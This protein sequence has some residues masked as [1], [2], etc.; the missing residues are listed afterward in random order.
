[1]QLSS[2]CYLM[3]Y[4]S[5]QLFVPPPPFKSY[6]S[7]L[8]KRLQLFL[9]EIKMFIIILSLPLSNWMYDFQTKY[10]WLFW[11]YL[12][13]LIT[14]S[15]LCSLFLVFI[16][17]FF[18]LTKVLPITFTFNTVSSYFVTWVSFFVC[19]WLNVA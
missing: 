5:K 1:M 12:L 4:R 6:L 9:F 2:C 13:G 7:A 18:N 10:V 14:S 15:F 8:Y 11:I 19:F 3:F 17:F 16:V